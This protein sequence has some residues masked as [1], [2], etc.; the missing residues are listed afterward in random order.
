[1]NPLAR[2][3]TS[4]LTA[5]ASFSTITTIVACTLATPPLNL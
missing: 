5:G 4:K 2:F 3:Y 1:M